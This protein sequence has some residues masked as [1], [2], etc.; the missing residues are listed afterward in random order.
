MEVRVPARFNGPP[1]SAQGGWVCGLLARLAAP[2]GA[3]VTLLSPPPLET[4]L[5]L[6]TGPRRAVLRLGEEVV[7]T[8]AAA[9]SDPPAV[10]P[11]PPEV[12][13][14]AEDGFPGADGH[15]FPTCFACG[16]DRADGLRLRPGPVPGRPG[17]A[18]CRW[19][20]GPHTSD[21]VLWAVLDCPGG[22]TGDPRAD[23]AV[24]TRMTA[25]LLAPP[26]PGAPHVVVARAA[27]RT[28]R[29]AV[30]LTSVYGPGGALVATAS[31]RWTALDAE[32]L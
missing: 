5:L 13:A 18:A 25:R 19:T 4:P 3:V 10:D 22:W 24:L 30:K 15:P 28:G 29:T 12:A 7:A 8:V 27:G 6:E 21:E 14:A 23:P 9:T 1:G 2:E 32:G 26:V 20:P 11:V 17:D 16:P 31:A